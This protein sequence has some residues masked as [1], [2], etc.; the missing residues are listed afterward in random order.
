MN[1]VLVLSCILIL[2]SHRDAATIEC[3][4]VS[5]PTAS[6]AMGPIRTGFL[7]DFLHISTAATSRYEER[8]RY[9]R[10]FL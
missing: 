7:R 5:S 1:R 6:R 9:I 2:A 4:D 8:A 10:L 3:A